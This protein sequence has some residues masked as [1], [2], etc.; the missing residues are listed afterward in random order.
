M[1]F[2]SLRQNFLVLLLLPVAL[3]LAALGFLGFI[4]A[5]NL[6]LDRWRESALLSLERAAHSIDMRLNQPR[7]MVELLGTSTQILDQVAVEDWLL[8]RIQQLPGV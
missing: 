7:E 1:A 4:Y 6:M 8:R 2:A 3:L 5:R